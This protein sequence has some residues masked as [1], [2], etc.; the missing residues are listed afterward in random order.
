MIIFFICAGSFLVIFIFWMIISNCF[1]YPYLCKK[2]G[3]KYYDR[4]ATIRKDSNSYRVICEDYE[5]IIP[6]CKRCGHTKK[7]KKLK[8]I[9][10]YN[11]VSMPSYMWETMRKKGFIEI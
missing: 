10:W 2:Y 4:S 5:C 6:T 7:P 9:N 8:S 11:S 3:H 1:L